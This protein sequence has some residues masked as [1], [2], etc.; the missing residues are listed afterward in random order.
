MKSL[1]LGGI[2]ARRVFGHPLIAVAACVI[3][4]VPLLYGALYLWAFWNPYGHIKDMPVAL[5]NKDVTARSGDTTISAGADIVRELKDGNVFKWEAM[6]A[7]EASAALREHRVYAAL[8][9]PRDFSARLA[10]ADSS[11]PLQARLGV[12]TNDADNMLAGQ[13]G[14]RVYTEVRDAAARSAVSGY[15]DAM[16]VGFANARSGM[17]DASDGAATLHSGLVD[18]RS[19]S[20]RLSGGLVTARNGARTLTSGLTALSTGARTLQ[21]GATGV[22][23]G[24]GTLASNLGTARIGAAGLDAGARRLSDGLGALTD[25]LAQL[26]AASPRLRDAGAQLSAGAGQVDSGVRQAADRLAQAG[27][28]TSQLRGASSQVADAIAAYAAT[29]PEAAGDPTFAAALAGSRQVSGGLAQLDGSLTAAAPSL[30]QLAGGSAQV[31]AGA[32]DLSAALASY[33]SGVGQSAEGASS[34]AAGAHTIAAGTGTLSQGM[35][36]ASAGAGAL[37]DGSAKLAGGA[38][39][40]TAGAARAGAGSTG[41]AAGL[42]TLSRG[43]GTL[44]GGLANAASGSSYLAKGLA[45]GVAQL[46]NETAAAR[47]TKVG[48]M[49]D[50]VVLDAVKRTS[51]P[52]YGTGFAPYFIPLALWVGALMIFFIVRPMPARALASNASDLV[53][54][55]SGFW[56]AAVLGAIQAA[57]LLL[58]VHFGLGLE[59]VMPLATWGLAILAAV[60]FVALLQCISSA[61]GAAGK[62]LAIVLLMLQLTSAAGTF[63]IETVP[64]FFQTISPF[65]PMTYVVRGLRQTLAGGDVA[66][67]AQCALVLA[68]F[69]VLGLLGTVLTARR[70]RVWTMD[71]LR[72]ALTI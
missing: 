49:S 58:V 44:A 18:A 52:N 27:D 62:L 61:L 6:S 15:L 25:G 29:H 9:I 17:A 48:V 57:F 30:S 24:T 43:A 10:S 13:I 47:S 71:R 45:D 64:R 69:L 59:P 72:P 51:V 50:P 28:A 67:V 31:K 20:V 8:T 68:G 21:A 60:T 42:V 26:V 54:V 40:L 53:I 19:G 55:F 38:I 35:T 65:L 46:P 12:T 23:T 32:A 36:A 66:V 37:A 14:T 33:T 5:V 3:T 11:A 56:P 4:L 39:A 2:E 41:L 16:F 22:A 63:P 1:R 7:T 34:A 70:Q